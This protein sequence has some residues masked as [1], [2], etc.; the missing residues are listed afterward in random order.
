MLFQL[1]MYANIFVGKRNGRNDPGPWVVANQKSP[2]SYYVEDLGIEN[3]DKFHDI[4]LSFGV[5]FPFLYVVHR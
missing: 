4:F 3:L 2:F 5:F 1:G